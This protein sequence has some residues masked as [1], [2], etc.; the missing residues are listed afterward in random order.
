MTGL[1]EREGWIEG[2]R[3]V[4]RRVRPSG[5]HLKNLTEL[6]KRTGWKYSIVATNISRLARVPGSHQIQ[7]LDALHRQHA[8]VEDRVRT[9]KPWACTTFRPSPRPSTE[10]GW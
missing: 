6:E 5:R 4:V 3:L 2:L 8:V 9:N 10:V 7:W 1:N